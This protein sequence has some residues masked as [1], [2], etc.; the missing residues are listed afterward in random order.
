MVCVLSGGGVG[1]VLLLTAVG[2]DW[3]GQRRD[4]HWPEEAVD[5]AFLSGKYLESESPFL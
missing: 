3:G 1:S 5:G 4:G 2:W